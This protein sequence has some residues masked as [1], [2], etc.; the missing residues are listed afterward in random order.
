MTQDETRRPAEATPAGFTAARRFVP[1]PAA[2]TAARHWASAV[3]AA[4]SLPPDAAERLAFS[5]TELAA[6]AVVHAASPFSVGLHYGDGR[7]VVTV[8]DLSPEP[9]RLLH[10]APE[11][12][13]GRGFALVH[14]LSGRTGYECTADGKRV[15]SELEVTKRPSR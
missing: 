9:P 15:W 8:E 12:T 2:V 4:W 13:A 11:A 7:I 6:N 1:E 5:V 14:A 3:G 10:A